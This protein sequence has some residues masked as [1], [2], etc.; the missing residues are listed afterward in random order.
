MG[1]AGL[2]A[3]LGGC[4]L[5]S[6]PPGPTSS[7]TGGSTT[8]A[9]TETATPSPAPHIVKSI[10]LVASIG[11]PKAWTPA[12]LTWTGIAATATKIGAAV[13]N[14]SPA[15][16]ADLAKAVD[17]AALTGAVVV[18]VGSA[19][20]PA[21]RIAAAAHPTTQFFEM[22]VVV[23]DGAPSNVHGLVFDEAE[24]GYLGGFIAAAFAGSGK[25]GMVG[26][27]QTDARSANY[28]AG[29]ANGASQAVSG[30]APA[31]AYVGTADS[32]DKGRTAAAAL[33]KAGASV[34]L[35]MP[36]LSGI[37]ALREACTRG[38]R[39]VAVETDAWQTVPDIGSCLIGSVMNRYDTAIAAAIMA[40][41]AGGAAPRM[42]MND[43]A[44]GGIALS[45]FHAELPSGFRASL[46]AVIARLKNG[47]P[48]PSPAPP[49]AVPAPS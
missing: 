4:G 10:V 7:P 12:G 8:A 43:V 49:T 44:N 39:L 23:P 6:N 5:F 17:G 18:T 47:P 16:N 31:F 40:V 24:A 25:V 27:T 34:L 21:V 11:E 14:A 42:T 29:F 45:D 15:S 30:I 38:A 37:G 20:D 2:A 9:S 13:S 46:D 22:D 1:L 19:A 35:A 48:R 28:A 36:S 3:L 26:D 32:P 41:D 33:V